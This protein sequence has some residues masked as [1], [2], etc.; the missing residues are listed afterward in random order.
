MTPPD[1]SAPEPLSPSHDV[2]LFDCGVPALNDWLKERGATN[3][4]SGATRTYVVCVASKVVGYYALA[5]GAVA[6]DAAPGAVRR[7]M[8]EP[9]PVIV[10][11]RLAIDWRYQRQGLGQA[12]LRDAIL[13]VLQAADVVGVRAILVHAISED[14][15]RFYLNHGFIESPLDPMTLCLPLLTARRALM[16]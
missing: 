9:V 6:R 16:E 15:R 8:P 5:T 1:L 7:N 2:D 14:V 12:L 11:G 10:L 4:A 13:R 3:E